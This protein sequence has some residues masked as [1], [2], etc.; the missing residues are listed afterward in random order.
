MVFRLFVVVEVDVAFAVAVF[1]VLL[2]YKEL[3][4]AR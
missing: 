4:V 1:V 2:D 3:G